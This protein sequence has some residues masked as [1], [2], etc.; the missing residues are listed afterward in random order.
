MYRNHGLATGD[1]HI[2]N[3]WKGMM[4]RCYRASFPAYRDYGA[5]GIEVYE[6]WRNDPAA[7]ASWLAANLGP[8][9]EGCTLDRIDNDGHYEPGNLQWSS[10]REQTLNSRRSRTARG[11]VRRGNRWRAR[12]TIDGVTQYLGTFDTEAEAHA[13][14][15]TARK[16]H[17]S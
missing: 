11:T 14:F 6:P 3:T 1:R 15:L 2:L 5:R 13:A 10:R 9:P 16:E 4:A 7:F 17:Q 8:R 12:I